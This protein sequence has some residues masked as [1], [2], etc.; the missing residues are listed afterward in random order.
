MMAD[1]DAHAVGYEAGADLAV[2]WRAGWFRAGGGV[3]ASALLGL[4]DYERQNIVVFEG[5]TSQVQAFLAVLI[6]L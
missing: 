6:D 4:P 5:P 2:W 1:F 3:G